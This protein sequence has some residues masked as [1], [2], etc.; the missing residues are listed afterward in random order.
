MVYC[1]GLSP[2][3]THDY[4]IPSAYKYKC[5]CKEYNLSTVRHNR[6]TKNPKHYTC[7]ICGSYLERIN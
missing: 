2:D 4:K 1:F 7:G 6:L 3:V 5:A